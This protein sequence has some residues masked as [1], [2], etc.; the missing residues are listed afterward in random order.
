MSTFKEVCAT[1]TLPCKPSCALADEKKG[2]CRAPNGMG[3]LPFKE[4][5]SSSPYTVSSIRAETKVEPIVYE[6]SKFTVWGSWSKE[7]IQEL[8]EYNSSNVP[9]SGWT[10][11]RRVLISAPTHGLFALSHFFQKSLGSWGPMWQDP[12]DEKVTFR[13]SSRL[14]RTLF[15]YNFWVYDRNIG[16]HV[17]RWRIPSRKENDRFQRIVAEYRTQTK[18]MSELSNKSRTL[19]TK[20]DDLVKIDKDRRIIIDSFN[21]LDHKQA[22]AEKQDVTRESLNEQ[23]TLIYGKIDIVAGKYTDFFERYDVILTEK[24]GQTQTKRATAHIEV[25]KKLTEE[26]DKN[27]KDSSKI[28][29]EMNAE[30]KSYEKHIQNNMAT[31]AELENL[32]SKFEATENTLEEYDENNSNLTGQLNELKEIL[33]TARE[34]TRRNNILLKGYTE[35]NI[36]EAKGTIKELNALSKRIDI[37]IGKLEVAKKLPPKRANVAS[38]TSRK[39]SPPV[40]Q[41]PPKRANVASATSRKTSPNST[42]PSLRNQSPLETPRSYGGETL[43]DKYGRILYKGEMHDG[44]PHGKG[45]AFDPETGKGFKAYF[46]G[47]FML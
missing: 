33:T 37:L 34:L 8:D 23:N 14:A 18:A 25:L 32:G 3:N 40:A 26:V 10:I 28:L 39:T 17:G 29:S 9:K 7:A 15:D 11:A 21:E 38:A 30:F 45:I 27:I 46:K 43:L 2:K 36:S 47:G 24:D 13:E 19:K 5:S 6:P 22:T 44:L 12:E 35:E 20:Y 41:Q 42:V 4:A 31:V 1:R 16:L